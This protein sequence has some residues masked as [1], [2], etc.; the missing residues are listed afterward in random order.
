MEVH[1]WEK[2]SRSVASAHQPARTLSYHVGRAESSAKRENRPN[3]KSEKL[4]SNERLRRQEGWQGGGGRGATECEPNER[5]NECS[6]VRSIARSLARSTQSKHWTRT[7][8]GLCLPFAHPI[9]I[10]LKIGV[11][12]EPRS[13]PQLC[14]SSIRPTRFF[15]RR[16]A[17][18]RDATRHRGGID[19]IG[20]DCPLA[21]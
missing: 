16:A 17:P 5:T 4:E 8:D 7:R 19:A 6:F 20:V 3:W 9:R 1:T 2:N 13:I 14:I 21:R 12:T 18:R 10:G 15:S 11:V